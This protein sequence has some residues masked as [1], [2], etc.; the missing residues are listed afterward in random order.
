MRAALLIVASQTFAAL[1]RA[2]DGGTLEAGAVSELLEA[3]ARDFKG[4]SGAKLG[5][6]GGCTIG[7][8]GTHSVLLCGDRSDSRERIEA[9]FTRLAAAFRAATPVGWDLTEA[10]DRVSLG[11]PGD[12]DAISLSWGETASGL[13]ERAKPGEKYFVSLMASAGEAPGASAL[14]SSDPAADAMKA[15][16]HGFE[17]YSAAPLG[18]PTSDYRVRVWFDEVE[19]GKSLHCERRSGSKSEIKSAYRKLVAAFKKAIPKDWK[20]DEESDLLNAYPPGGQSVAVAIS[21]SDREPGFFRR[22][23][24][25]STPPSEDERYVLSLEV[26]PA[27]RAAQS[28]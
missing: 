24:M 17:R 6:E 27:P 22:L 5:L 15:R 19:D 9:E 11:P 1:V 14:P 12:G 23:W 2:S 3:R 8:S 26:F 7:F 4:F 18:F 25:R 28:P 21:W 20:L 13:F 16:E 10:R